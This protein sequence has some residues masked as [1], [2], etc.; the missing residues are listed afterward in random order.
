VF[1]FLA[2]IPSVLESAKIFRRGQQPIAL[3]RF[4]LDVKRF[5]I[6]LV[7][8]TGAVLLCIRWVDRAI[9]L[10][11]VQN[12]PQVI[13]SH[14]GDV[15]DLLL[16]I[17]LAVSGAS[18][19]GYAWLTFRKSKSPLRHIL[20]TIGLSSLLSFAGKEILH[21]LFGRLT[22]RQWLASPDMAQFQFLDMSGAAGGFPSGH[23]AVFTPVLIALYR[24]F[25]SMRAW[26]ISLW[27]ALALALVGGNYH[28]V[29]DVIAGA[30]L[31]FAIDSLALCLTLRL[32]RHSEQLETAYWPEA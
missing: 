31:G 28:F 23:M 8:V 11:L 5:V 14:A 16:P 3:S 32:V 22:P 6:S 1:I 25:P 4:P 26:W 30:Y 20:A 17:T 2:D 24:I 12:M 10:L 21:F 15:P 13:D 18:W 27:A 29:S 19:A 7:F 9:A